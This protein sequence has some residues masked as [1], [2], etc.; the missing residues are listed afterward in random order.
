[1]PANFSVFSAKKIR[2]DKEAPVAEEPPSV[3]SCVKACHA[4]W[5]AGLVDSGHE[6]ESLESFIIVAFKK[7]GFV[8]SYCH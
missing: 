8:P 2:C 4:P 7:E 6:A 1:M 5:N 3:S